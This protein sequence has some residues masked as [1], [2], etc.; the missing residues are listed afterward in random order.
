MTCYV[1]RVAGEALL[2]QTLE[3]FLD[4]IAEVAPE[5]AALFVE[6]DR[7]AAEA[8]LDRVEGPLL[9]EFKR[10]LEQLEVQGSA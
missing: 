9:A 3:E 7:A 4:R 2:G 8:L 1:P 5:L 10:R 6:G